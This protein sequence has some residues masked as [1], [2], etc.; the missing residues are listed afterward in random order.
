MRPVGPPACRL[1]Q[2]E[3]EQVDNRVAA[4]AADQWGVLS[5]DELYACGL[6]HDG[7]WV[8]ARNGRLHRLHRGV[9]AVGHTGLTLEGRFLA[10][11]K[12]CGPTA[13]LSHFSAAALWGFMTWE[14][15]HPEVTVPGSAARTHD[16]INAHRSHTLTPGDVTRHKGIRV[17]TAARTL[18]DL[19]SKLPFKALRRA[20][21]QA[22]SLRLLAPRDLPRTVAPAATRSELEDML[23][24]LI[25]EA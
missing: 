7:V 14:E 17:T 11:V 10:A 1:V 3:T 13:T 12:A 15:R 9:Y 19:S 22:Q 25:L 21:R 2:P 18:H 24:D 20:A 5:I 8:R 16:G 6:T 4:L 23:L